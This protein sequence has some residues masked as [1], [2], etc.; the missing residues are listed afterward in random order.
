ML[1]KRNRILVAEDDL[2]LQTVM[3]RLLHSIDDKIAIDWVSTADQAF[4]TIE[5]ARLGRPERY[6]LV[7]A[8]IHTPGRLTG[9][10]LW[11]YCHERHP[12][13]NFLITSSMPVEIYLSSFEHHEVVPRYLSKPFCINECVGILRAALQ[14][15]SK[16]NE[17]HHAHP[18]S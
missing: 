1:A 5:D 15:N 3:K 6:D 14:S 17:A 11:F 10:Q 18:K 16:E 7:I 9:L 4:V 13:L 2:G 12:R 8:D